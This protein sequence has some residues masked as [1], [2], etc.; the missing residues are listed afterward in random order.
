MTGEVEVGRTDLLANGR[1]Q[2]NR[3]TL[4]GANPTE[5]FRVDVHV[6]LR[7]VDSKICPVDRSELGW[8]GSFPA[9]S[10]LG[11]QLSADRGQVLDRPRL[12]RE[13]QAYLAGF[14]K[15]VGCSGVHIADVEL[16]K[17]GRVA[18]WSEREDRAP[19]DIATDHRSPGNLQRNSDV[20][21][22]GAALYHLADAITS[23]SDRSAEWRGRMRPENTTRMITPPEA[24]VR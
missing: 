7:N 19:N 20:L 3:H 18:I 14:A 12:P 1:A 6:L 15:P 22:C 10:I 11:G 2:M 8:G 16:L 24:L 17:Y 23:V 5:Q 4:Y 21:T 13:G 9:A